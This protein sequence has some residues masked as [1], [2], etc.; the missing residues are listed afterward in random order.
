M[1]VCL[2]ICYGYRDG[3]EEYVISGSEDGKL[4]VWNIHNEKVLACEPLGSP[5][6]IRMHFIFI[7]TDATS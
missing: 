2:Q 1:S 6:Q 4:F 7:P 5:D 3:K